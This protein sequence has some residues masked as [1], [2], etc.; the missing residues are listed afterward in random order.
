[1]ERTV[2]VGTIVWIESHALDSFGR[3]LVTITLGD[4]QALLPLL[5]EEWKV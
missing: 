1:M 2:P 4:G 5:P 3:A